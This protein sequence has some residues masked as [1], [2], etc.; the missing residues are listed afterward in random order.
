MD[1]DSGAVPA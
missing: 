1:A